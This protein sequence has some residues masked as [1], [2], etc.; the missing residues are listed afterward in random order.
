MDTAV[1]LSGVLFV[2][3]TKLTTGI[4]YLEEG[5]THTLTR[6]IKEDSKKKEAFELCFGTYVLQG[7]GPLV[8]PGHS[9]SLVPK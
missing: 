7:R 4:S 6:N 8:R 2:V 5:G 1:S 3:S 9:A